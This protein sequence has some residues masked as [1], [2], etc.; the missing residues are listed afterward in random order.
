MKQMTLGKSDLGTGRISLG[1][2]R[3]SEMSAAD[4]A[5]LV[6]AALETGI[7]L[8][9]HADIY[10]AGR[11]EE[12][13]AEAL[14]LMGVKRGDVILQS[15][16]GIRK[17][18]F[19]FSREHI[20]TSVD[21][22]LRRLHTEYLDILLLHRPDTLMESDEVAEAF[23][24]LEKAGKVR[25]FGVSNQNPMQ[26]K[27]LSKALRQPLIINQLQFSAANAGMIHCGLNVNME[28]PASVN[29]DG[30]VLEYCRMKGVTIQTWSS[31]QYGFFD[32][33]FLGSDRYPELNAVLD[34]L[35]ER[36]AV[37]PAAIAIAWVLRH[38]ARMQPVIGTTSPQ[39][40][41][42]LAKACD[43]ELSRPEWY[44]IYT[45]AGNVLP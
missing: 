15:K 39:R 8:F 18:Y 9:D 34:R 21:G 7:T 3:I 32:G 16:C 38:P 24:R 2:M 13:F 11:S 1:C 17:G 45:A 36:Y 37:T 22:I 43:V 6:E 10:G 40:V 30:S 27:F 41:W 12:V 35:A 28:N 29:R 25:H 42:E 31:L 4:V 26:M 20:L 19:D 23:D 5:A 33:T 14:A 44:E